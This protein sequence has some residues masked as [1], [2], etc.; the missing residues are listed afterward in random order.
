M[1]PKET[2]KLLRRDPKALTRPQVVDSK[3]GRNHPCPCGSGIKYKHC[4]INKLL[5]W[6][7]EKQ[8]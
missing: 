5:F 2:M 3:V 1:N 8:K 4:H 6:K 7:D